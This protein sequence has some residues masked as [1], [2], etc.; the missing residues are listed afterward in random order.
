MPPARA[1]SW[2]RSGD[3][4]RSSSTSA[5]VVCE[6]RTR[7]GAGPRS[8]RPRGATASAWAGA[9]HERAGLPVADDS[10]AAA[11]DPGPVIDGVDLVAAPRERRAR[12]GGDARLGVDQAVA[13]DARAWRFDR[14]LD[15]HAE[16]QDVQEH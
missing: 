6:G 13:V 12:I 1:S 11:H 16:L 5:V 7:R 8:T 10:L 2:A 4:S 3:R 15:V 9:G 14:F